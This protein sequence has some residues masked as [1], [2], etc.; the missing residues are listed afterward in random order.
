[1]SNKLSPRE[2]E[3]IRLVACGKRNSEIGVTLFLSEVGVKSHLVNIFKKL[4][5]SN[6]TDAVV[7]AHQQRYI[8]I[9]ESR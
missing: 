1:L 3:I 6:R 7:K 9:M 8:N 5:A 2:V 4:H